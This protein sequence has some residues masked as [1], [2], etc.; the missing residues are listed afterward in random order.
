MPAGSTLITAG[1]RLL[2]MGKSDALDSIRSV[3]AP[4]YDVAE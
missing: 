4:M 1:D 2:M 3:L